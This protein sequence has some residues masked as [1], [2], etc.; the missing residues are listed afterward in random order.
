MIVLKT[1]PINVACL[2]QFKAG[3]HTGCDNETQ[4]LSSFLSTVEMNTEI[5]SS[6][7]TF[8]NT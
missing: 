4:D 7:P 2:S 3:N 5:K 8:S 1:A 6:Y